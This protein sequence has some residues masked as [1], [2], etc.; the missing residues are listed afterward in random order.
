MKIE[1]RISNLEKA[2][3]AANP[4]AR[5]I[6]QTAIAGWSGPGRPLPPLRPD[7]SLAER[8]L[9]AELTAMDRS[10]PVPD[11]EIVGA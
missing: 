5:D 11:L 7:A 2:V 10:I 8:R 1:S 3:A 9:H 6:G 4:P